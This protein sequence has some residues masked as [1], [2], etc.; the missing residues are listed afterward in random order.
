MGLTE[1]GRQIVS[2]KRLLF[3]VSTHDLAPCM[4]ESPA[5]CLREGAERAGVTAVPFLRVPRSGDCP[6]PTCNAEDMPVSGTPPRGMKRARAA[7]FVQ[8]SCLF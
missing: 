2:R 8:K 1:K 3:K 7:K 6:P 5:V 4:P